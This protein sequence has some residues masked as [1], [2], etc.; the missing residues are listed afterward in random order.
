VEK[1]IAG[2]RPAEGAICQ[3]EEVAAEHA[4]FALQW[5][6]YISVLKIAGVANG[7]GYCFHTRV[8]F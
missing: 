1:E 5:R 7:A 3:D 2:L 4:S 8:C 6:F